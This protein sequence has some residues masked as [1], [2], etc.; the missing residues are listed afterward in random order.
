[1]TSKSRQLLIN[2]M[3]FFITAIII[4]LLIP[5]EGH[6]MQRYNVG[7]VWQG[8]NLN[9]PFDFPITKSET[10]IINDRRNIERSTIPVYTYDTS[11]YN[12]AVVSLKNAIDDPAVE[13]RAVNIIGFIYGKGIISNLDMGSA[14]DDTGLTYIRTDRSSLL[15]TVSTG[16]IF[17]VSS[18]KRY[19]REQFYSF[20]PEDSTIFNSDSFIQPNLVYNESLTESLKQRELRN[21]ATTRGLVHANELIV[22]HNQLID[23]DVF[24]KLN[25]LKSEYEK[26]L[27]GSN[28][29]YMM[30]AGHFTVVLLIFL[31]TFLFFYFFKNVFISV[32]KNV[33][34][35]LMLYI[36][37]VGLCSIVSKNEHLSVYI[38]PFAI[39][40]IYILTFFDVRMSVYEHT[41]ILLL[42]S[43][44]VPKPIEFFFINFIAGIVAIFIINRSYRR[45]NIFM[46][47]GAILLSNC[48]SYVAINLIQYGE[49][50]GLEWINFV[51]FGVNAILFLGMY[52]LIYMMEKI[53]GFVSD[54]TLLE[55]CDTNQKL[56]LEL[57]H[58]APG[59]F[60][61]T[62]Q[63]ANMSEAAAT[64]IDANPLLARAGSM[65]H[66]IGK[67]NNPAF[68][69]ENNRGTFNPH[70]ELS[71][72][73]SAK[74]ILRHVTDGV[75][76]AKKERL[77]QV[78]I[79]F[80]SGH[81]GDSLVYFFYC[82]ERAANGSPNEKDYRYPGPKPIS[83]EV[84]ICMIA[85]AVE[86]ASHSL[87]EYTNETID[88]LVDKVVEIKINDK[89]LSQ[90]LL[91]FN[92]ISKIKEILKNKLESIYHTRI[93]Y[94]ER[95]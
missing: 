3:L 42:C 43:L 19:F 44:I 59:T 80:I 70:D 40:P 65:Y 69:I 16:E 55:L 95:E 22:A 48:V 90:S 61:H 14:E 29:Y 39:V 62:L 30:L 11:V 85:D 51:W 56:L 34:F 9:A 46:A 68:F 27:G 75:A 7:E 26:R 20:F 6:Y 73:E 94:P 53:F 60:Q 18:A 32:R 92:D 66:D 88:Q 38:I 78:I 41:T 89:E 47:A 87:T 17:T 33:L 77:P 13:N 81:H 35:I 49:I 36:L 67:I 64:A 57:A 74:I 93:A 45:E 12:M 4:T 71:P 82:K 79:N 86:A 23:Q 83:K 5:T 84:S 28:N 50:N 8:E 63:V 24:N 2:G 52:Q 21:V 76:L 25:S 15:E 58:K 54:I 10:E 91:S 31:I 1:M 37:M 72:R